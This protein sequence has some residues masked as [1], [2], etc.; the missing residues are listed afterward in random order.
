M[1]H[2]LEGPTVSAP[3]IEFSDE[4]MQVTKGTFC[5]VLGQPLATAFCPLKHGVCM[6]KHRATGQ[7]KFTNETLNPH[8]FAALVGLPGI[9]GPTANVLR[10]SMKNRLYKDLAR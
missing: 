5:G 10:A 2:L 3:V 6:W 4:E 1:K 8:Q 7:C 9:D